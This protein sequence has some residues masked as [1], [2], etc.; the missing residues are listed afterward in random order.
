MKTIA[1]QIKWDF[2]TNGELQI[3]D[4]N[5]NRI[6]LELSNGF[7][8]KWEYDSQVNEIY[9]EDSNGYWEKKEYDSQGNQIYFKNS[10]GFWKKWKY[11]SQGK[12]IYSENTYGRIID[13]RPKHCSDKEIVIEGVKY[14]LTKV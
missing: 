10:D 14:K 3:K 1:E 7:W 12:L 13:E 2:K 9:L 6:Y 4:K 11:D 8:R 5:G